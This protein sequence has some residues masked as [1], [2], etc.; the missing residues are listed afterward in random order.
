MQLTGA[1]GVNIECLNVGIK[2]SIVQN[3]VEYYLSI[4]LKTDIITHNPLLQ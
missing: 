3:F 2:F 4:N 1:A